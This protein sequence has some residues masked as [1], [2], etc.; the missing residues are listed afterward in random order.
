MIYA[1]IEYN[2]QMAMR[3]GTLLSADVY[4]PRPSVP[5]STVLVRTCYTK[6]LD[7][8][9]ERAKFWVANGYA[10]VV[11]DVRGR[12]DSD[13]RFYPFIHETDDGSDTLDWIATQSWSD[14]RV[15]MIG[16]S[17]LGQTQMYAVCSGNKHLRA[18]VPVATPA[19]PDR[20]FPLSFG[21]IMVAAA[22]W[23][24]T[25][26]G[27]IN[28]DWRAIDMADALAHRP[29][30]NFDVYVGRRLQPWRDWVNHA[31][32]DGY[33]ARQRYQTRLLQSFQPMLHISGW[34]D[35]C[36]NGA[37]ENFA[38]LSKRPYDGEAPAQRLLIGPWLHN[39]IGQRR[40]G[41]IDYGEA[42][43]IDIKQL[44]LDWFEACL[45]GR[46]PEG[47]PV[48]LFVM[49]RN[50]W[51]NE[52]EWPIPGTAYISYYLHSDGHA[53][54]R[55]GDG[56]LST[57]PPTDEPRDSF[58]YDPDRPVPYSASL[59]WSQVGGREDCSQL[60]TRR[61]ILVYTS[62]VLTEPLVICG[63]LR[64]RLFAATS[65]R[66]TDWTAKILDVHPDGTAIRL[67]DGAIRARFRKGPNC[68]VLIVPGAIEEYEIDCWATCI[69]LPPG[70]RVRLE[71]SSSA[72][73]K[74]DVNLNGGCPVGQ[75]TD[76]VIAQQTIFHDVARP[77][78]IV[79]P[80]ILSSE[81]LIRPAGG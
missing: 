68:E 42:A 67:N 65:A 12:G 1:T 41:E 63:P 55:D 23:M 2:V 9:S 22:G 10:Y 24:A 27:H 75:E 64:V 14:G 73:G 80:I 36:L 50:A 70:H 8:H 59:E 25:L 32:S 38:A 17:Y 30:V 54:T 69:E 4:R 35:D 74:F 62:P 77:S 47:P 7:S 33:W 37:L 44:Q 19:D 66:D 31:A 58:Q 49:G 5:C 26:D 72:F 61:D 79:L 29:I 78:C 39:T 57:L 46:P 43:E 34:Y 56:R 52:R 45:N 81:S 71:I 20:G 16:Q 15:V 18:V 76:A 48:R 3:D 60:E 21:M 53:N 13:G 6:A 40:I 28:Q 11:Q 51:I